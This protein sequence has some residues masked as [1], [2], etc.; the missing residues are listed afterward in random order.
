MK[1]LAAILTAML[2][3]VTVIGHASPAKIAPEDKPVEFWGYV[4]G[5]FEGSYTADW[6]SFTSDDPSSVTSHDP[7]ISTYAAA[8]YGGRVYG[9]NYGYTSEGVLIDSY[10]VMDCK[11]HG[12]E[13]VDGAGSSGEFVYGMAFNYADGCMYALC[14]EDHPYIASVDLETGVLTRKVTITLGSLLGVQTLAIDGEGNFYL[15]SF[16]AVN[17]VLYRLNITTGALTQVMQT[18]MPCFYAQSMTWDHMTNKLYWAH[19]NE[20]T[21]STNGLY[22]LDIEAGAVRYL[23]M[24]GGG[25]EIMCLFT[26]S[27]PES[28]F[29][30]GD[31]NSDGTVDSADALLAL[32]AA[33]GV[34]D[35]EGICLEAGDLDG[36][37]EITSE[38]A[39]LI[40]RYAMGLSEAL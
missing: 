32:R 27:S 4:M 28:A 16:S 24:I 5:D 17:S 21:S 20:R 8:Y 26:E 1:K 11:D 2:M 7:L 33:M 13:F 14:D 9:Y 37:G 38:E 34:G 40:L 18:G 12:I 6:I 23:G 3:L 36:D 31:L 30:R 39:L 29:L 22:E 19:V 10:Y 35:T 25:M 15:L